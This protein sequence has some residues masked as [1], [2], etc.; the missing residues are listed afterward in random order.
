[1]G[2]LEL[3]PH[4]KQIL[5][6]KTNVRVFLKQVEFLVVSLRLVLVFLTPSA[7]LKCH[8]GEL[9]IFLEMG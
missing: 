5:T 7:D 1:M 8:K 3:L 9:S 2:Q 4:N 6:C